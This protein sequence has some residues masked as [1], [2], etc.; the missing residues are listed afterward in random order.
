MTNTMRAL[1]GGAGPDWE[2][3]DV[4]VPTPG[5]GQ[6]L[7]RV[8]AAALNRADLY[9][10]QGTYNPRARTS[11]LFTAGLELAGEVAA[12][13]DGVSGVTVGE[14][15]SGVTLGAFASYALVDHRHV[16]K[17]PESLEWTDAAALPVGLATEHD[18]LVQ[19]GFTLGQSVLVV[20]ATSSM[21]LL[22]VQLAK[23]LGASQVIATTTSDSKAG[24]LKSVGA[25]LVV[26]TSAENLAEAVQTATSGTGVDL[27]LDHAGGQLFADTFLATRIGGTVV[28]VGRLAGAESTINLDQ[29]A[30]RRL[31]VLGTTFSVRTPDELADVCVALVPDV[32][33]A[34][35]EG[36]VRPVVDRVFAFDDAKA[37]ADHMRSDQAVGKIVLTLP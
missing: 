4:E 11:D 29:L 3:C 13:G 25:D 8:R 15:V 23:V 37:A 20:G 19:G 30:F 36:R 6:L 33:P 35:A 31:R 17:V 21:G 18:A 2:M 14:R 16:I 9:M 27:V 32:V 28:N 34:V 7:V 10:L 1:L 24:T 5:S 12:V 22:A 26:D